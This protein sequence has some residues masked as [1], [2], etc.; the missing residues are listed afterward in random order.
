MASTGKLFIFKLLILFTLLI[1]LNGFGAYLTFV[2]QEI[3]QPDGQ[4]I[5]CF[6]SGDEFYNWL[7]DQPDA[8]A[9]F[10]PPE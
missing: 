2:P 1:S 7:V 5:S 9:Q 8:V 4:V 3:T 6:G 10:N